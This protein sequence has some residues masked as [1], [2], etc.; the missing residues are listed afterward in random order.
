MKLKRKIT[1]ITYLEPTDN[2]AYIKKQLFSYTGKI[3]DVELADN[4]IIASKERVL[5]EIDVPNTV[6]DKYATITE[7]KANKEE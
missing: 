6:L 1:K 4:A 2:E 3:K 5:V 7:I